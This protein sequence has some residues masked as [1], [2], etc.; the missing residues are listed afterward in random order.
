M[1]T[2]DDLRTDLPVSES[3]SAAVP[4][5]HVLSDDD[6]KHAGESLLHSVLMI[7]ANMVAL[8]RVRIEYK[9][10][11]CLR[12]VKSPRRLVLFARDVP[13]LWRG[14]LF[15]SYSHFYEIHI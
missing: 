8:F 14:K 7:S 12:T 15:A 2:T 13:G 6:K 3:S 4:E 5:D 1:R 10:F 11:L 9:L